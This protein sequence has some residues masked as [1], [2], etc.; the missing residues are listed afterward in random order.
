MRVAQLGSAE[1]AKIK[2]VFSQR[3]DQ[4]EDVVVRTAQAL[5]ELTD[6]TGIAIAPQKLKAKLKRIRLIPL[7]DNQAL[8]VAIDEAGGYTQ[9]VINV[10]PGLDERHYDFLSTY[11]TNYIDGLDS[12]EV[13]SALD[14]LTGDIREY[15]K[16]FGAIIAAL[17]KHDVLE[18]PTMVVLGTS[19]L[20]EQPEYSDIEKARNMIAALETRD[21]LT[22]FIASRSSLDFTISIGPEVLVEGMKNSSLVTVAYR[23]GG[24]M[25][26][27]GVIGPTRMDYS[28][29]LSVMDAM[30]NALG[31]IISNDNNREDQRV[32]K[33]TD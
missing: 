33:K 18:K 14:N 19:K 1:E 6:Y 24:Q 15:E 3:I 28:R 11:L 30:K 12:G 7:T 5:S 25:G 13:S 17:H 9:H 8:M 4:L 2:Q 20:L 23:L 10:N 26:T 22:K 31:S 32:V 16:V 29:V 21:E 27:M